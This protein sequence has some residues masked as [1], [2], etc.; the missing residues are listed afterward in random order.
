MQALKR[1]G[2]SPRMSDSIIAITNLEMGIGN[3]TAVDLG[4]RVDEVVERL[5]LLGRG[6]N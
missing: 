2:R 3:R 1:R 4:V 5:A 6:E